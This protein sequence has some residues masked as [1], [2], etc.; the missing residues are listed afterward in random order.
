MSE[1]PQTN[2]SPAHSA[3]PDEYDWR[4]ERRQ[5]LQERRQAR[6]IRHGGSWVGGAILIVVGILLLLQYLT[7][8][9]LENWW[10]LIIL[11]PAAGAFANSWRIY[12]G[13][14]RLSAPARA[15]LIGGILLTMVAAV[16]LFDLNWTVL[17]PIL[18]ILAGL[19]LLINVVL[20]G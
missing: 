11:I 10:A 4:S 6:A 8:F 15:S 17:G 20:P 19:G 2:A 13:S 5:R 16:F 18:I 3:Q 7:S 9:S 12:Q 1:H 14:E